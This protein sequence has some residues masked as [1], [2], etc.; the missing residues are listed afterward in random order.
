LS[1]LNKKKTSISVAALFTLKLLPATETRGLKLKEAE[2]APLDLRGTEML[3][4]N[5]L[6]VDPF[7]PFTLL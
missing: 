1:F 4:G 2:K 3:G 5:S 7:S 6:L